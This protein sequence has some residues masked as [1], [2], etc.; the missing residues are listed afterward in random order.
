MTYH[1]K[2]ITRPVRFTKGD[3]V[4]ILVGPERTRFRLHKELLVHSA[5]Y[6][7]KAF[8]GH[9]SEASEDTITLPEE[10]TAAFELFADWLYRGSLSP[11]PYLEDWREICITHMEDS[12]FLKMEFKYHSLYYMADKW[13]IE[14]LKNT[15]IDLIRDFHKVT[16]TVLHPILLDEGY[17]NTPEGSPLRLY[18]LRA[19]AYAMCWSSSSAFYTKES[20]SKACM[21]EPDLVFDTLACLASGKPSIQDPDSNQSGKCQYHE[22]KHGSQCEGY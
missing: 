17:R 2:V 13:C 15:A 21:T 8:S 19:A 10:N 7:A 4:D 16:L 18:L 11:I 3:T 1:K 6:F 12:G 22:H 20:K 9:F 14:A 5:P